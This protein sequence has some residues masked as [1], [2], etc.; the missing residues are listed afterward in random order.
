M[1]HAKELQP[2]LFSF[3]LAVLAVL[4]APG[5]TIRAQPLRRPM[6]LV[7]LA[8]LPS[9]LEPRISPDGRHLILTVKH[10]D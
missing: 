8:D 7:D 6:S 9:I 2:A 3:L 10:A 1:P 5:T 4:P